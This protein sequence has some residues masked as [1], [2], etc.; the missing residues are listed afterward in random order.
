[1]TLR[2]TDDEAEA[3]RLRSE[4]EQR[5][6]QEIAREA[7]RE[8]IEAHSRAELLDQVLDEELPRYAEALRWLGE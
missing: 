8:Y 1:M 2:L 7:I 6:M 4:L 5:S 3:L